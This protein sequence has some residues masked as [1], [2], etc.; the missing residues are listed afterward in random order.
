MKKYLFFI[1]TFLCLITAFNSCTLKE[2]DTQDIGVE[3]TYVKDHYTK[4]E[5]SIEMRDGI[6]LHT[7]IYS[8]KDTSKTYPI[9][10]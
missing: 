4:Q 10:L 8:P 9:L 1:L 3:D 2:G 7:S 5:I 6:L